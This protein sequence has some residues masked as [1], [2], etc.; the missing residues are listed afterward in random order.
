MNNFTKIIE[1]C[2]DI[3]TVGHRHYRVTRLFPLEQ[4]GIGRLH[5]LPY[6]IRVLLE[7]IVRNYSQGFATEEMILNLARWS[8]RQEHPVEIPFMP[9]RVVLQDF[10]G[11]PAVVDLA[12]MR[13]ALQSM[14]GD[15][16]RINPSIPVDLV[17]DHSVQVDFFGTSFA[18]RRN[19]EKEYERNR[20]RYVFLKWAQQ[21]F[22]NFRV[23][24]PGTGIV[25]QVNLEYLATVVQTRK[26]G[27]G[28]EAYPDTL[29]GT[30]SHTT[31]INGL[32]ILGWGVGGIEAEAV[33]LQQPYF[34]LIPEVIGV[35]LKGTLPP[36]ATSTDLVLTLTQVLRKYEVV[37]KFVEYFGPGLN[38][39]S[40]PDRATVANMAPEYGATVGYFPVDEETLRY[41]ES[42][43]RPRSLIRLVNSYSR[44]Q[45]L[46]RDNSTPEPEYSDV[47]DFDLGTVEPSIAGPKNPE[48][49][50]PLGKARE[51]FT[52]HVARYLG[53]NPPQGG[54]GT[55]SRN[56]SG[57]LSNLP[58]RSVRVSKDGDTFSVGD[59][60]V[61]IAA[62]TSC[63]NTSNPNV[64]V[65]A[66]LLARNAVQRG[67]HTP[68]YVKTSLAPGS[69]LVT[70]YLTA[71]NLL[72]YLEAL[73]FH[74]VGYG[75]TTCI[76]NSGPLPDWLAPIVSE[77]QLAVAAVLSG[78]RN[79]E[80]RIHP[81]VWF[82]YLASPMLVVAYALAGTMN[83][84]LTR[85]P[86]GRDPNGQPVFLKDLWPSME[87]IQDVIH[88]AMSRKQ[89]RKRYEKV[90]QGDEHWQ[91]LEATQ[92]IIY[93][94]DRAS[95]YIQEP[96]FFQSLSIE[97]E[98]MEDIVGARALAL[99]GDRITTDHISPAGSISPDGPAGRYLIERGVPPVEFNS[100][101]SRR[102]NHD[103]MM[104]GTFANVRLRN[105]LC[106][107]REGGWTL[108]F[109][110]GE[111]VPIYEAAMRYKE[112]KIPLII[113]AGHQYGTGSSRDWAA[114]GT[115]LLGV[116]VVLAR[117]YE[118]IHR[119][120]LVGMG[121]LPL[122]FRDGESPK[123]LG[124]DG[125]E[126]YAFKGLSQHLTPRSLIDVEAVKPDGSVVRF[127]A[128][129][130]LDSAVEIEYYKH[131]GILPM[132]LRQIL[133]TSP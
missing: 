9:G 33:M 78:N 69:Q 107:G 2:R 47:L 64:M 112:E 131:K 1:Q 31:M 66:G 119:S 41:L 101:G 120:N 103:V 39:L 65:G 40:L 77:N 123:T 12:A 82:N 21:N 91:S 88:R 11:V 118:R 50:I 10:T 52:Q 94:W 23:V 84:D 43:G 27:R 95:T 13:S 104:R 71:A 25:H 55:E 90:F 73:G 5:R 130:R 34:M 53:N 92:G 128:I 32:G 37:G 61:V 4:H 60:T 89:F 14:G 97:P 93:P 36:G 100:F 102:G 106:E 6:S 30:D 15:P 56:V 81:Q 58:I 22:L 79:F 80:A 35:R 122:Q 18:F 114:K 85:D 59:G 127:Q 70:D 75:C 17:V 87:E 76:G 20:E 63:T 62:I 38:S 124:L 86:L 125:H 46:F 24:P 72:P 121:V 108:H 19:V 48:E 117:S 16:R 132:V 68:S 98:P 49:R 96:P 8:P 115:Y 28:W 67:L 26:F 126:V 42:T 45:G 113:L 111:I 99:L 7:N 109:P 3:L 74:I 51:T 44:Q 110:T 29:L 129:A 116:K 105:L 133:K 83:I 57:A 54:P